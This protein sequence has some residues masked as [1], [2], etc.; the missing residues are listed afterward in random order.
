MRFRMWAGIHMHHLHQSR[1]FCY[2]SGVYEVLITAPGVSPPKSG[3]QVS[4]LVLICASSMMKRHLHALPCVSRGIQSCEATI[5]QQRPVTS[6]WRTERT[7]PTP[8]HT[9][10]AFSRVLAGNRGYS[11]ANPNCSLRYL[12]IS[13]LQTLLLEGFFTAPTYGFS[14]C[15]KEKFLHS[16]FW[17]DLHA[18]NNVQA[19]TVLSCLASPDLSSNLKQREWFLR[20]TPSLI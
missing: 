14:I 15:H 12:R 6:H 20:S 13:P 16:H 10:C 3:Y 4:C 2:D 18:V 9:P 17:T 11:L 1:R 5:S 8:T 19:L 7:G